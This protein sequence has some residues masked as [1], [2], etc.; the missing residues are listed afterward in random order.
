MRPRRTG[1]NDRLQAI[2]HELRG[3]AATAGATHVAKICAEIE[4]AARRGGPPPST[5]LLDHLGNEFE[6]AKGALARM[7]STSPS[8]S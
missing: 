7:V 6:R 2:S 4:S 1:D 5:D 3:A 8:A